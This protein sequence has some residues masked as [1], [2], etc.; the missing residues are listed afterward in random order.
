[1]A[2]LSRPSLRPRR[3]LRWSA[4]LL[5]TLLLSGCATALL[6][7]TTPGANPDLSARVERQLHTHGTLKGISVESRG[8]VVTLYGRVADQASASKA[9]AVASGVTGVSRVVSH[10][11]VG[12]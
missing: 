6:T 8:A 9:I 1:M 2:P 12:N 3:T 7:D 10:L 11:R 5:L 4:A